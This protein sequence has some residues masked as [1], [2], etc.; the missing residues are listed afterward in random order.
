MPSFFW[1]WENPSQFITII[2]HDFPRNFNGGDVFLF[3]KVRLDSR[4]EREYNKYNQKKTP[5]GG[6]KKEGGSWKTGA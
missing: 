1:L 5:S 2:I 3:G 6:I 4:R